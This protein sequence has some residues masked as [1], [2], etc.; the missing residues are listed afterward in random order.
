MKANTAILCAGPFPALQRT[1]LFKSFDIGAVNRAARVAISAAGKPVNVARAVQA[2]GGHACVTGFRGGETGRELVRLMRR[3]GLPARLIDG[4]RDTRICQTLVDE[5]RGRVTEVVEESAMP[6]PD[7]WDAWIELVGHQ[8]VSTRMLVLSGTL[9][10]AAPGDLWRRL[11]RDASARNVP[12]VIDSHGPALLHALSAGP[13]LVKP[14]A[15]ELAATLALRG[16]GEAAL[17]RGMRELLR[18][19]AHHVA[20]TRG[21]RDTL[22]GGA[23]GFYALTPPK[24]ACRNPIGCGDTFT[25]VLAHA[26][27]T[28]ATLAE[29]ARRATAAAS[30]R[31]TMLETGAPPAGQ[32]KRWEQRVKVRPYADA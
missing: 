29:A 31:C 4:G 22:I 7:R 19:G 3:E 15:D 17:L 11:A 21:E 16:T 1:L 32:V 9:P 8:L 2:M 26:A 28:G 18:R 14:N 23:E 25:G 27:S 24:A 20:V 6:D 5:K 12:V 30:V 13:W 10:A